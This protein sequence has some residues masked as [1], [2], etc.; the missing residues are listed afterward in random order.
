[1]APLTL[2]PI[3]PEPPPL[4]GPA[5]VAQSWA[6]LVFLHWPYRPAEVQQL[7]PA[8][9]SVDTHDGIAWVGLVPFEMLRLRPVGVPRVPGLERFVEINVR[10]YVV[11]ADGRRA[12][13]FFSLDVPEP[14]VVALARVS[15]GARYCLSRAV[16]ATAEVHGHE[17]HGYAM[18]RVWPAPAGA[19]AGIEIEVGEPIRPDEIDPLT[20]FLTARWAALT[21]WAGR[22]L[23]SP[24]AHEQWPLHHA[25]CVQLEQDVIQAAGLAG[26]LDEPLVHFSPG[27]DARFARPTRVAP[28][29]AS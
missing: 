1:V 29:T 9:V 7:L 25:T 20:H 17:R 10:T 12:V 11:G 27:V 15:F 18:T 16:H 14:A 26:P 3:N 13:W 8:G 22:I 19:G 24:V 28:T 23:R 4:P 5:V 6:D 21:S 2:E